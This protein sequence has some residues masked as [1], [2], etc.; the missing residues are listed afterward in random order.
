MNLQR[1]KAT[2]QTPVTTSSRSWCM[3]DL[4]GTLISGDFVLQLSGFVLITRYGSVGTKFCRAKLI[5]Q[6][7]L[8]DLLDGTAQSTFFRVCYMPRCLLC[9]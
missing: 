9:G 3:N 4:P 1:S 7:L 2:K 6:I 5:S 8:C